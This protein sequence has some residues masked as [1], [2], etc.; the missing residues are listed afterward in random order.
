MSI[1]IVI[2][3]LISRYSNNLDGVEVDGGTV[4]ECLNR[5]IEQFPEIED[6]LF[7]EDGILYSHFSLFINGESTSRDNLSESVSD[8][9]VILL[10]IPIAGG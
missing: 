6:K 2:P 7:N 3:P 9:D 4:G 5:L 10:L 1:E 8:G